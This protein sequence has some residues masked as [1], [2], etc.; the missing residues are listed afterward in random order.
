MSTRQLSDHEVLDFLSQ[1]SDIASAVQQHEQMFLVDGHP[2]KWDQISIAA[3][4]DTTYAMEVPIPPRGVAVNNDPTYGNVIVFPDAS[5]ILHFVAT[6]N[7]SLVQEIQKPVYAS[8]PD[9]WQV[10]EEIAHN[11]KE[12]LPTLPQIGTGIG[13]VLLLAILIL[14]RK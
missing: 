5:G 12:S 14:A 10:F 1:H 3:K 13:A 8:D 9:Y 2:L 6:D 4:S 7:R 11:F